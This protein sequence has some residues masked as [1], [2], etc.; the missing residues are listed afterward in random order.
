M[1]LA[2][3]VTPCAVV[4]LDRVEANCRGMSER[5]TRLGVRLRPHVKT[6]KCIEA[7]RLAVAGHFGGITVS[8]L[9]EAK[10]FAA[11]GFDDITYAVPI[12]PARA[13]QAA[14][15]AEE[16][17]QLHLLVDHPDAVAALARAATGNRLSVFVKVDCGY[18]RA[19]VDPSTPQ[20]DA[21][22]DAIVDTPEL[23]LAGLLTHGGH[24]YDCV[25]REAI[26]R[27]AEQERDVVVAFAERL[28]A[29]GVP[30]PTVSLGSTPTMS[31]AEEL[32]GVTEVRPGNYVFYDA[33]QAAIGSCALNDAALSVVSSIIGVYP[34]RL[35]IDAGALALSKDRGATHAGEQGYGVVADLDARPLE[36][37]RLESLS[38]EHGIIRGDADRLAAHRLGDRLRILANHSCLTAAMHDELVVVRGDRKVS[39]WRPVRGW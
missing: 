2:Q 34:D 33:F 24:S 25:G 37:L 35:V 16:I 5:A 15:L 38:Q 28:R 27:V 19:G 8:T 10:H 11:A 23:E 36:R 14:A 31:V 29:R 9:A 17:G 4:D 12:A 22:V 13:G 18:H 3:A 7:A 1:T 6:H 21:L 26:K 20:A 39:S 30:V 32:A